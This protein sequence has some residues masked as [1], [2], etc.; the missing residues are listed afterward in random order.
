MSRTSL[1]LLLALVWIAGLGSTLQAAH[2]VEPTEE[3]TAVAARQQALERDARSSL[4]D[5]IAIG[6]ER[7]ETRRT[8]RRAL[9]ANLKEQAAAA[10]ARSEQDFAPGGPDNPSSR[11]SFAGQPIA[12]L[13]WSIFA[14]GAILFLWRRRR[15]LKAALAFL[16]L[17]G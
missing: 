13:I 16:P 8:Y 4:S 1:H 15:R 7:Y 11:S 5:K 12:F 10:R 6:Q 2:A 14:L 17:F 3:R 9:V